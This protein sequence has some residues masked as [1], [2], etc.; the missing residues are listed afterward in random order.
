MTAAVFDKKRP[1]SAAPR[2]GPPADSPGHPDAP[3]PTS[4]SSRGERQ[5]PGSTLPTHQ[6]PPTP[7]PRAPEPPKKRM[8]YG[9][10]KHWASIFWSTST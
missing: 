6:P 10:R 5:P 7:P 2:P 8:T 4:S 3:P 1:E 9:P